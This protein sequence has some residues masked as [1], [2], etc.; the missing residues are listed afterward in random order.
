M[1][2]MKCEKLQLSNKT[3]YFTIKLHISLLFYFFAVQARSMRV[4]FQIKHL[5][6]SDHFK[7]IESIIVTASFSF[8][9]KD[10]ISILSQGSIT[11][12]YYICNISWTSLQIRVGLSF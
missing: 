6:L 4:Y 3:A 10:F 9:L 5:N 2:D 8:S 12:P 7:L 1:R 11:P